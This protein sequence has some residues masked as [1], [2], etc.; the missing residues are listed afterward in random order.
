MKAINA[1][2]ESRAQLEIMDYY[3][4]IAYACVGHADKPDVKRY[5]QS[6]AEVVVIANW[7]IENA[8]KLTAGDWSIPGERKTKKEGTGR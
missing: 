8:W 5:R 4:K 6:L 1:K 3:R 2:D 7:L